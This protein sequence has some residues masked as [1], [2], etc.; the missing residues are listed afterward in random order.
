VD[1][2]PKAVKMTTPDNDIVFSRSVVY[3]KESHALVCILKFEFTKSL[4]TL[5]E[6]PVLKEVYKKMFGFLK[7]P[8]VLKKK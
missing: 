6:Y 2:L 5:D 4:Y 1:A 8:V 3:D 7:E